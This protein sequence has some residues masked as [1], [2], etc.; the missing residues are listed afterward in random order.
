MG[1]ESKHQWKTP[2][3]TPVHSCWLLQIMWNILSDI[4]TQWVRINHFTRTIQS[5]WPE[6]SLYTA[7]SV[8]LVEISSRL[9]LENN[10]DWLH[11]CNQKWRQ[12]RHTMIVASSKCMHK[13]FKSDSKFQRLHVKGNK[14]KKG[15]RHH[16]SKSSSSWVKL[17]L[18]AIFW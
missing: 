15:A 12:K 17:R 7:S 9:G 18:C 6:W 1:F 8:I 2:Q 14:W 16:T 4:P 13:S 5:T 11:D 10:C 3:E